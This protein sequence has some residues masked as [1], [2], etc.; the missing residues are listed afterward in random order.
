MSIGAEI[1]ME[2]AVQRLSLIR[3]EWEIAGEGRPFCSLQGSV[4]LI[5]VDVIEALGIPRTDAEQIL[6]PRNAQTIA[7]Q[8]SALTGR[9]LD[10][11][12]LVGQSLT[13]E[14]IAARLII[15]PDT[16]KTH[17]KHILEK[18][19]LHSKADLRRYLSSWE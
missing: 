7:T 4:K 3:R 17:I 10:I 13:N 15:S 12:E 5:L 19:N 14:Q 8:L 1:R 2:V 11:V 9:E 6:G 16:V 18:L